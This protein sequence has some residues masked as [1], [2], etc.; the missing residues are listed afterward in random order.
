MD[1]DSIATYKC[2]CERIDTQSEFHS[3]IYGVCQCCDIVTTLHFYIVL[4]YLVSG[5]GLFGGVSN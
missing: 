3:L 1:T 4:T 5:I 2:V